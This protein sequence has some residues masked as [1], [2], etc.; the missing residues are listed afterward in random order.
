[1]RVLFIT[2]QWEP[3]RGVPQ[4]RGRWMADTLMSR[5]HQVTVVSPP[6]HYPEGRLL[7]SLPEDQAGAVSV[8]Q[9]GETIY[10]AHFHPHD[11]RIS[12]RVVD[13]AVVAI[14]SLATG[15]RAA[16]DTHP[17]IILTT[18]PPLPATFTAFVVARV[19]RRPFV[20]DLRDVWPELTRFVISADPSSSHVRAVLKRIAHP[21]FLFAGSIFGYLLSQSDGVLTTSQSHAQAI[22]NR[23]GGRTSTLFNDILATLPKNVP[24]RN[25]SSARDIHVLYTGN[26]GRAQG[27]ENAIEAA[28]RARQHGTNVVLRLIG[29]GAHLPRIKKLAAGLPYIEFVPLREESTLQEHYAWADTI[30]VHL[31]DWPPLEKTIPSKLFTA[32]GSGLHVCLAANGEST[33]IMR[34]SRVGDCVPAMDPDA[35][36]QLWRELADSRER[37][38]VSDRG[39]NWLRET[40]VAAKP[41]EIFI[42]FLEHAIRN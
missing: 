26:I 23:Y 18:S 35:L 14:S 25:D 6:P 7:S 15:I 42:D 1:M 27:L 24:P 10:R 28:K 36:A 34:R 22:R 13:Q 32:I 17:D 39:I 2:Q 21:A 38:D 29:Q 12:T 19:V 5:G 4:R 3:E 11:T 41:D 20:V 9:K 16:R 33:E 40:V 30:L 8:S 37:L 31:K